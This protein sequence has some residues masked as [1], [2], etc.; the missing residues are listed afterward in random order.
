MGKWYLN[1]LQI[2][3]TSII[4]NNLILKIKPIKEPVNGD[5]LVCP[6]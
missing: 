5:A 3:N 4:S 2:K 6:E 1:K